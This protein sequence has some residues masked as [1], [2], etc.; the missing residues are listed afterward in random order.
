MKKTKRIPH[1]WMEQHVVS[2]FFRQRLE[3]PLRSSIEKALVEL[4]PYKK[5]SR[6]NHK[7]LEKYASEVVERNID[8][9]IPLVTTK[10]RWRKFL[11]EVDPW[12]GDLEST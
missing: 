7:A 5:R 2:K 9:L 8:A 10:A 4:F 3:S 12:T 1:N 6:L 11:A